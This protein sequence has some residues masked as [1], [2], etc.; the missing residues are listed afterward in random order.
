MG[1]SEHAQATFLMMKIML[2]AA[3]VGGLYGLVA[4]RGSVYD[5]VIGAGVSLLL[6]TALLWGGWAL[7]RIRSARASAALRGRPR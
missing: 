6:L 4:S 1:Q 5:V 7:D 2:G 3:G